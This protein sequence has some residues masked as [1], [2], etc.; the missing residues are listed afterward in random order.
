MFC[1]PPLKDLTRFLHSTVKNECYLITEDVCI[2]CNGVLFAARSTKVKEILGENEN[3]S[4]V[5]F[6][7]NMAGLEDC[8][9]LV[10]GRSIEIREDNFKSVY[11]FGKLFQICEMIEGVLT[12]IAVDVTCDKFW[13]IYLD[14]K[15]VHEDTSA[16]VDI[17][18]G[19][20]SADG[21][22]FMEHTTEICRNQD[23][24]IITAVVE[25]LSRI[26]DIR[27]L[28]VMEHVVDIATENNET[29]AATSSSTYTNNYLQTVVSSTITF[30]ENYL[31][32]KSCDFINK[33]YFIQSINKVS[34]V[35][36]NIKTFRRITILLTDLNKM[37]N[38]VIYM[39]DLNWERVKQLTSP[40]TPYDAIKHF[41]EH[42]RTG[43]HP[44][45]VMDIALKWWSIRAD[46]EHIDMRFLKPLIITIQNV[47][48]EWRCAV[49]C[50]PRYK[51]L[52]ETL[53]IPEITIT[54]LKLQ[55]QNNSGLRGHFSNIFINQRALY[56][57]INEGDGEPKQLFWVNSGK[58][59]EP[60]FTYNAAA[61][62]PYGDTKHHF[63]ISTVKNHIFMDKY[64]SFIIDSK[65]DIL[66]Y[67]HKS[68]CSFLHFVPLEDTIP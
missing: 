34:T 41:T 12:W 37:A 46:K 23:R 42:A 49:R 29:L 9:D 51:G 24:N 63:Y 35:C 32:E 59:D 43:I 22:N 33:F 31:K 48:H 57:F 10:Y 45:V 21:D 27:A 39:K 8:L 56:D 16:F 44:C 54:K 25:L 20:L 47:D 18:V 38:T 62:P 13:K 55:L 4:A 50:D 7:D 52:L 58:E 53:D 2:K 19:Y 61:F 28:S 67:L 40:T 1:L 65:E 68:D 66:T 17:M 11:K 3:I 14:L 60:A 5:E 64:V 36:T 15:N 26:Y 30:I 6:S